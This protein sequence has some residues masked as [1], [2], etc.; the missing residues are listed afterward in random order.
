[1]PDPIE[2]SRLIDVITIIL[3]E[4][5]Q[6]YIDNWQIIL[7]RIVVGSVI[8]RDAYEDSYWK[9]VLVNELGTIVLS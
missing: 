9:Y 8:R 1:M 2:L 6:E 7:S 5:Q 4:Q 3:S